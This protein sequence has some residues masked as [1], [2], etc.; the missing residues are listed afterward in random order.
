[1]GEHLEYISDRI[2]RCCVPKPEEPLYQDKWP[3]PGSSDIVLLWLL[4]V[5]VSIVPCLSRTTTVYASLICHVCDLRR[6]WSLVSLILSFW[7]SA[8]CKS[9]NSWA[10][11]AISIPKFLRWAS[12][13][14]SIKYCTILSQNNPKWRL[15][16]QFLIN[17]CKK[18]Y[19]FAY[20]QEF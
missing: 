8:S 17:I 3:L 20:L 13:Q 19:T 1:M 6:R 18:K 10:H 2:L 7:K 9:A 14:I 4:S 11:S 15:F 12:P 16:T 5:R